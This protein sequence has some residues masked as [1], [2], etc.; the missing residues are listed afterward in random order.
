MWC[1]H[2]LPVSLQRNPRSIELPH[3]RPSVA[4][5]GGPQFTR[6][7][8]QVVQYKVLEL[9]PGNFVA[10]SETLIAGAVQLGCYESLE[11]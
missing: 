8:H 3:K 10:I 6:F 4:A 5:E 9:T 7:D 2:L 1:S 11:L